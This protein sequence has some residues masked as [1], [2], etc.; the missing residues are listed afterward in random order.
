MDRLSP[1]LRALVTLVGVQAGGGTAHATTRQALSDAGDPTAFALLAAAHRVVPLVART[2][3]Q[4]A[5][6]P[7]FASRCATLR[8]EFAPRARDVAAA[9]LAASLPLRAIVGT[10]AAAGID[11]MAWKGPTL[12]LQAWGDLAARDFAD[13]DIVV[14]APD[15]QRARSVLREAGWRSRHAMGAAAEDVIFASQRAYELT[16]GDGALLVELHWA[17]G[18]R[19]YAGYPPVDE[20]LARTRHVHV[21]GLAVRV[22]SAP[23]AL[24]LHAVHATKHG[25]STLEDVVLFARLARD[26]EVR[27]EAL[28][29]ATHHA[30]SVPFAL[31]LALSARC[32]GG[33][34]A[35]GAGPDRS[36]RADRRVDALASQVLARW[37]A[38]DT[39]WRSTLRWDLAWTGGL[40]NRARLLARTALDPTLQEWDA[41]HLPARLG[42]LY[43]VVR[44]VRLA[45][46]TV[47]R[48]AAHVLRR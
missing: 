26:P 18:A 23:D 11:A 43:R 40:A 17:F 31:G 28:G 16:G 32:F 38:G 7:E 3:Q 14:R 33:A 34:G 21:A 27:R 48:G 25:W 13:L 8:T 29:L 2:L 24:L 15:H 1:E 6:A 30:A 36:A 41:V 22:P 10:L 9:A 46:R 19:R 47:A 35:P 12:A 37:A 44:P 4:L 20:V 45:V 5:D 39:R 42:A